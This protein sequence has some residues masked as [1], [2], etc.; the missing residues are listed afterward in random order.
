MV[1]V[2]NS[3]MKR[4]SFFNNIKIKWSIKVSYGFKTALDY[5]SLYRPLYFW[6]HA[7]TLKNVLSI[8]KLNLTWNNQTN[9]SKLSPLS[10]VFPNSVKG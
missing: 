3:K 9:F 5:S 1:S 8:E 10:R 7:P 2:D 6:C 4:H